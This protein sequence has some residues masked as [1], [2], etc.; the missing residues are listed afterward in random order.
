MHTVTFHFK[1]HEDEKAAKLKETGDRNKQRESSH[2][3]VFVFYSRWTWGVTALTFPGAKR[4]VS[5]VTLLSKLLRQLRHTVSD[6]ANKPH[7]QTWPIML[8]AT[9]LG[10]NSFRLEKV[11]YHIW[12]SFIIY[13]TMRNQYKAKQWLWLVP[14]SVQTLMKYIQQGNGEWAANEKTV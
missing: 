9:H 13:S 3:A 2:S 1:W 5:T 10:F 14:G 12:L 8:C 4:L 6:E 11:H 7:R